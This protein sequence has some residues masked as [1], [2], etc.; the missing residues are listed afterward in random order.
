MEGSLR[1]I[2]EI[3]RVMIDEVVDKGWLMLMIDV[4]TCI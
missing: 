4:S 1:L 3:D 2:F